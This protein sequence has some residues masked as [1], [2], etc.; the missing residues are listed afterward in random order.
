MFSYTSSLPLTLVTQSWGP[1]S[2]A[3]SLWCSI[4]PIRLHPS[5]YIAYLWPLTMGCWTELIAQKQV[6]SVQVRLHGLQKC[7]KDERWQR[8]ET[9][10]G[11]GTVRSQDCGIRENTDNRDCRRG[12]KPAAERVPESH[13]EMLSQAA[14]EQPRSVTLIAKR[15]AGCWV[16]GHWHLNPKALTLRVKASRYPKLE[17]WTHRE[18]H[19]TY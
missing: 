12:V 13:W 8:A 7:W 17:L 6:R 3:A 19:F 1:P 9:E 15:N 14:E 18:L 2:C 16:L 5:G 4:D 10:W 11:K